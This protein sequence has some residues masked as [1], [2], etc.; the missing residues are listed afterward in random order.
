MFYLLSLGIVS[1][2][3]KSEVC[4]EIERDWLSYIT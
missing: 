4:G 3:A 1:T 2:A